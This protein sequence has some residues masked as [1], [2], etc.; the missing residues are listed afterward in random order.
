MTDQNNEFIKLA[1]SLGAKTKY[2]D[3]TAFSKSE[4]DHLEITPCQLK[5]FAEDYIARTLEGVGT[6]FGDDGTGG[7]QVDF[8]CGLKPSKLYVKKGLAKNEP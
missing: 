1:V 6:L 5:A 2:A 8:K 7:Y 3:L 4:V